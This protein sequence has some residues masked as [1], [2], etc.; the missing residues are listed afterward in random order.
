MA[1]ILDGKKLSL[2]ILENLKSVVAKRN[3]KL[4]MAAILVGSNPASL[5]FLRQ[6]EKA[7][8][9]VGVD[10]QLYK[11]S[12]NINQNELAQKIKEISKG[13]NQGIIIQL[14]LPARI[15]YA[16]S[17]AGGPKHIN[18]QE[19]LNLIPAEK[20]IDLLSENSRGSKILSPVLGG[21]LKLF[22]EYKI[23]FK[24]KKVVV[25]GKGIL[26]GKPVADWLKKQNIDFVSVNSKTKDIA[27]IIKKADILISGVGKPGLIK[28]DMVKNGVIAVDA[29]GGVDFKSVAPRASFITPVPGGIGPMTVAMVIENLIALSQK[30]F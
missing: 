1:I 3:L 27:A 15:G 10:F 19:I 24:N 12:E 16:K 6:K 23:N 21:I 5:V 30:N 13:E 20:D 25:V 11:F 18:A 7:C 9:F 26:V 22:Q 4:A 17:V 2:K 8:R 28:G 29:A 14:P